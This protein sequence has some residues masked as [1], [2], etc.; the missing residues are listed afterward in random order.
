MS[1]GLQRDTAAVSSVVGTVLMLAI[2]ISV[3][4]GLSIVIL[5]TVASEPDAPHADLRI[6]ESGDAILVQHR[7]GESLSLAEGRFLLNVDGVQ[8]EVQLVSQQAALGERWDLG[9]SL[10]LSCMYPGQEIL[11]VQFIHGS[12]LLLD[13]GV[14]G[15]PP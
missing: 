5:D 1:A 8:E 12:F 9:E 3:F 2:T 11:G 13:E 10:C 6:H 15:G 4:S 7:R 14:P